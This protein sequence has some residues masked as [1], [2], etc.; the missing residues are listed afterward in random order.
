MRGTVYQTLTDTSCGWTGQFPYSSR[1]HWSQNL[2]SKSIFSL[3]LVFNLLFLCISAD[4]V[5]LPQPEWTF[6]N[7]CHS[8]WARLQAAVT[9]SNHKST[10]TFQN[11]IPNQTTWDKNLH[12]K[13][14]WKQVS[15]P[16]NNN[17]S[18]STNSESS[19]SNLYIV[20]LCFSCLSGV[21]QLV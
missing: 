2:L 10:F 3:E 12:R 15:Q 8:A 14:F 18:R 21:P 16:A 17:L 7:Y 11:F 1:R 20:L 5:K 13:P 19:Y 9:H 6:K 4:L